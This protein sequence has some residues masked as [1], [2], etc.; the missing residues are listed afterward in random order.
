MLTWGRQ[1]PVH[2]DMF[3]GRVGVQPI[4]THTFLGAWESVDSPPQNLL[5][6]TNLH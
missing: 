6:I 5:T 3:V 2:G 4:H 1:K